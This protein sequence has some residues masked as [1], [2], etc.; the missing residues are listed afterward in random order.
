M[1][2]FTFITGVQLA[3]LGFIECITESVQTGL[4]VLNILL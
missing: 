3:Y 1:E 4:P 2:G